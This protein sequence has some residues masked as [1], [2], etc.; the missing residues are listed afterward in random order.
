MADKKKEDQIEQRIQ[1]QQ[2]DKGKPQQKAAAPVKMEPG[3]KH[4]VRILNTDLDGRKHILIALTKIKGVGYNFANMILTIAKIDKR[5]KAGFLTEDEVRKLD[6][7][8][9]NINRQNVP[10]W[11]L[12]RNKDYESGETKHIFTSDLDFTRTND[13]RRL[14]RVKAVKGLRH[15]WHLPVRG[16]RTKS[17]FRKNKGTA[18]G[19][20][21]KKVAPAEGK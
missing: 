16:Q 5:K 7:T 14:Q 13:I 2:K 21:R 8:I 17:N 1:T 10:S 4:F 11:M 15:A 19:V 3:M 20:Q 18:L 12:N 6:D 9:R